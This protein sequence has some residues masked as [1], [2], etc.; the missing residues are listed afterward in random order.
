MTRILI[1]VWLVL[2]FQPWA[3]AATW[4]V[5]PSTDGNGTALTYGASDGT[6]SANAFAG[7]ADIAG[8]A[9]GDTVCLPGSDQPF[10]ERLVTAT[11]GSVGLPV[12]YAGCD[13]TPA[14]LWHAQAITGNR[15]FNSS[16]A[17]VSSAAYAWSTVSTDLYKKRIDVRPLMLWEDATWLQPVDIDQASEAT[18]IGTLTAGQW[19]VRDTGGSTYAIYYKASTSAISPT[20]ATI[21]VDNIP[22]SDGASVGVILN[23]GIHYQVFRNI[24]VRGGA[25]V[26]SH[27]SLWIV[28][29]HDILLDDVLL[30]RN[31]E[32]P[33]VTCS[34]A[35]DNITFRD[36]RALFSSASGAFISPETGLDNLVF[37]GGEYSDTTG[38]YF[39]GTN[40]TSGDG[41]GI[42]IGQ[43]GGTGSNILIENVVLNRNATSAVTIGTAEA[44]TITN[45]TM[46]GLYMDGNHGT[47]FN[48]HNPY[49]IV[50][51]LII[52]GFVCSNSGPTVAAAITLQGAPPSSLAITVA[53]GTFVNNNALSNIFFRPHANATY[54]FFNLVFI[55]GAITSASDRGD[56]FSDSALNLIGTEQFKDL[57][58]YSYPNQ[59]RSFAQLNQAATHYRYNSGTDLDSF[60][61]AVTT[62][63]GNVLNTD[64]LLTADYKTMGSSPL[65]RAGTVHADCRDARGRPCWLPP[66]IGAYQSTSGDPAATRAVRN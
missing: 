62:G 51:T 36:T 20:T 34:T 64:P 45:V 35:C 2:S 47:C 21:R 27:R 56:I 4:Y 29:S 11:S 19:G 50:G 32:G 58:F 40:F 52:T 42:G 38:S 17:A 14:L 39:N 8:I 43:I 10:F 61:T 24:E 37:S 55:D 18:I 3:D 22:L 66:D 46:R 31:M 54:K 15:S 65:R 33:S 57:Y 53:N 12:T 5:R 48:G 16:R 59:N 1:M 44:M 30:T 23:N 25:A 13:D 26:S 28:S 41:D 9:A 60:N 49:Q 6:S 63:T 7:F